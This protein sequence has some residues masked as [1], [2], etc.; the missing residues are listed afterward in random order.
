MENNIRTVHDLLFSYTRGTLYF[1]CKKYVH[2]IEK[3]HY[4]NHLA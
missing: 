4:P 2:L 3:S 1:I